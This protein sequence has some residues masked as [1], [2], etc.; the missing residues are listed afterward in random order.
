MIGTTKLAEW[1]SI[2]CM[3]GENYLH[4]RKSLAFLESLIHWYYKIYPRILLQG[5]A[6]KVK[7]SLHGLVDD[8]DLLVAINELCRGYQGKN[9]FF[10]NVGLPSIE[11]LFL[12]GSKKIS[13]FW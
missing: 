7:L 2:R 13:K 8:I 11:M 9:Q 12:N 1:W 3:H 5:L 6:N 10:G 4:T